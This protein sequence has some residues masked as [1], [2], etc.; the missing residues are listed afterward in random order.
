LQ[1][2]ILRQSEQR[3]AQ[4]RSG[5]TAVPSQPGDFKT[6]NGKEYKNATVSRVEPD[7]LV[8]RTKSGIS[9]V[10]FSELPKEV[11]DKWLPPE[12]KERIAA[13]RVAEGKRIEAQN[14]AERARVE[15]G[16][17]ADADLKRAVE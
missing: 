11:I 9:K 3:D 16:K 2:K 15:R 5:A 1:D 13:Q 8:L 4:T 17:N 6:I 12:D 7:G 14:A 10:Y